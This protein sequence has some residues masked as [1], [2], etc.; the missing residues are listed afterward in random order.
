[1]NPAERVKRFFGILYEHNLKMIRQRENCRIIFHF[2]KVVSVLP[3]IKRRHFRKGRLLYLLRKKSSGAVR[4]DT[5]II[6]YCEGFHRGRRTLASNSEVEVFMKKNTDMEGYE[7]GTSWEESARLDDYVAGRRPPSIP[8][9]PV[10]RKFKRPSLREVDQVL[11]EHRH[12]GVVHAREYIFL[13]P[14]ELAAVKTQAAL[15]LN[16]DVLAIDPGQRE[17]LGEPC[18]GLAVADR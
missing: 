10:N 6:G 2:V 8:S 18:L 9:G 13:C 14:V 3:S 15:A 12:I 11:A 5:I 1:M 17:R 4:Y 7:N 16:V